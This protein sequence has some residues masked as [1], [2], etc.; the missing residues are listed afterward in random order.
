MMTEPASNWQISMILPAEA[1]PFYE[2][3]LDA[4]DAALLASRSCSVQR[5]PFRNNVRETLRQKAQDP[6]TGGHRPT[7]QQYPDPLFPP[8]EALR[9]KYPS[10]S[11]SVQT[12]CSRKNFHDSASRRRFSSSRHW[13]C[14]QALGSIKEKASLVKGRCRAKRGGGI[15]PACAKRNRKGG[16]AHE[17]KAQ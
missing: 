17:W 7:A 9:Q 16:A 14:C 4:D 8:H 10:L 3:A 12:I 5:R 13:K 15:P 11:A 1:V 2:R 6:L